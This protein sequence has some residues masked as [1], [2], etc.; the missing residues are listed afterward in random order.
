MTEKINMNIVDT[1]HFVYDIENKLVELGV[2]N[3][4]SKRLK[5]NLIA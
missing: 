2:S 1:T 5:Q 3:T 4:Y